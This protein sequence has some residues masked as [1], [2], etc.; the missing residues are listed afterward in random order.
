MSQ[1]QENPNTQPQ[2]QQ[3]PPQYQQP[4]YQQ[5]PQYPPQYQPPMYQAQ[6]SKKKG[7]ALGITSLIIGIVAFILSIFINVGIGVFA[8]IPSIIFGI[9]GIV[10]KSGRA[11]SIIGVVLSV[12]A[13]LFAILYTIM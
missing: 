1:N 6:M 11:I 8:A 10:K 12:L 2:Y 13:V 7:K 9:I 4:M 3:P 5:P